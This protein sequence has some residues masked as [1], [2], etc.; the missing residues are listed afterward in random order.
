[1]ALIEPSPETRGTV[2]FLHDAVRGRAGID[3]PQNLPGE[4]I[5]ARRIHQRDF[6]A[7]PGEARRFKRASSL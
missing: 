2:D 1:M 7:V 4:T 6:G 3:S 5:L